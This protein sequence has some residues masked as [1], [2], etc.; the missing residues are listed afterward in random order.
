MT[1]EV[2]PSTVD[3]ARALH[4]L[5]ER[6]APGHRPTAE[7]L[8]RI[9]ALDAGADDYARANRNPNTARAYKLDRALWIEFCAALGVPPFPS[10][11]GLLVAFVRWRWLAG[12]S[13]ATVERHIAGVSAAHTDEGV[14]MDRDAMKHARAAL[15]VEVRAAAEA[16]LPPRGRGQAPPLTVPQLRRII[17][18]CPDDLAGA[19][20]RALLLLGFGIAARRSELSGLMARDVLVLTEGLRVTTRFGKTGGRTVNV[21]PGEHEMTDPV[22]A[23]L[24]WQ[25]IAHLDPDGPAL[26]QV[27]QW[28]HLGGRMSGRAVGERV[29]VCGERAGIPGLTGHSLRAGL[30]TS[31]RQAGKSTEVI[32]DQGGWTRDSRALLGY[33]RIV[34]AW[35]QNATAGIG[36]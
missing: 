11:R 3:R 15:A 36:L 29:K 19:R 1:L 25:A 35:L 22:Q 4:D 16:G 13:P 17:A 14:R 28:G 5:A 26:L 21:L 12:D 8:A 7:E 27:D 24:D 20:D 23:W 34:D 18:K 30:A 31:S 6:T 9:A 10:S 33:I 32:A 2:V